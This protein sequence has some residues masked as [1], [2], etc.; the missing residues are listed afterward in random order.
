VQG[1]TVH[2]RPLQHLGDLPDVCERARLDLDLPLEPLEEERRGYLLL[3]APLQRVCNVL[4]VHYRNWKLSP[5]GQFQVPGE[6][7]LV[8]IMITKFWQ[9]VVRPP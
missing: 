9:F 8:F 5:P 1:A 2:H 7:V 3:L 6:H 4:R